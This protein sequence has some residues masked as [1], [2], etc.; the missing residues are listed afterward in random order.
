MPDTD[1]CE[2]CESVREIQAAPPKPKATK[3]KKVAASAPAP[4]PVPAP[5]PSPAVDTAA[6]PAAAPAP[7]PAPSVAPGSSPVAAAP[8]NIAALSAA[9]AAVTAGAD[10][11]K[12]VAVAP[13]APEWKCPKLMRAEVPDA[14]FAHIQRWGVVEDHQFVEF[15]LALSDAG[16]VKDSTLKLSPH[17]LG[18]LLE[19]SSPA[20]ASAGRTLALFPRIKDFTT[21]ELCRRL[22]VLQRLNSGFLSAFPL[23][24]VGYPVDLPAHEGAYRLL[25]LLGCTPEKQLPVQLFFESEVSTVIQAA[26][27]LIFN[28]V[29]VQVWN[30]AVANSADAD[31]AVSVFRVLLCCGHAVF[32]VSCL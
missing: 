30:A 1:V 7:A 17:A 10:K 32:S 4:A 29:K 28:D 31:R 16:L 15:L 18:A 12:E 13:A 27:G 2:V 23:L 21:V 11:P 9:I 3:G 8:I 22:L 14:V 25:P 19:G 20:S 6:A 26:K 24:K 5:V